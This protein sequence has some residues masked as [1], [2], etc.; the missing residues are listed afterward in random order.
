[1]PGRSHWLSQTPLRS[2]WRRSKAVPERSTE[3]EV[4]DSSASPSRS[5]YALF[6]A[7]SKRLVC[8][9]TA[10]VSYRRQ[11]CREDSVNAISCQAP[12]VSL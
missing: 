7:V 11:R 8:N 3:P 2:T 9:G 10:E 12:A 6:G 1:M 4:F 5:L